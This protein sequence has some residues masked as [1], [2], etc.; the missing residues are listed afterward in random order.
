MPIKHTTKRP[1]TS[2]L[3]ESS[4]PTQNRPRFVSIDHESNWDDFVLK[5]VVPRS[6]LNLNL[7]PS[8][9][10]GAILCSKPRI[11]LILADK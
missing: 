6:F 4:N 2:Q 1:R 9:G 11:G 3:G 7:L 10:N 5:M 8:Q